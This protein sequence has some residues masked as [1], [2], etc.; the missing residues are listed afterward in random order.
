MTSLYKAPDTNFWSTTLNGAINS[1]VD[2]VTLNSVTDLNYPG[3]LVIDREDGNGNA[4]PTLREVIY[5]T[6]IT[7]SGLTGVTRGADGSTARSH[8][9]GALV[10]AVMTVGMWTDFR[11]TFLVGHNTDGTHDWDGWSDPSQTWTRTGDHTFTI[12][13]DVTAQ[14]PKGTKIR[15]KQG[16]AYEYG[17]VISATYSDPNTTVTLATNTDYAMAVGAITD[18]CY[19]YAATPQGFPN[20]F[21][22]TPVFDGF[23]SDPTGVT[24]TFAITGRLCSVNMQMTGDGTSNSANFNISLPVATTYAVAT[25]ISSTWSYAK[26]NGSVLT[27][28]GP[29]AKTGSN[30]RLD[31]AFGATSGWTAS[32]AKRAN[33]QAFYF[34]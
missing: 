18:N 25:A 13:T 31:K 10:E 28:G 24:A 20:L 27:A 26:D 1:S 5:F 17:V 7:G 21:N 9:D 19:S 22:Y 15:Y 14:Y 8:N 2:A 34:I 6:G 4:T 3:F 11:T 29:I 32:G 16:G 30:F 33:F 23:S 12:A